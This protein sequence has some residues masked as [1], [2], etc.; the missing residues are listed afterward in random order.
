MFSADFSK[1]GML[2]LAS[3]G[4]KAKIRLNNRQKGIIICD[5]FKFIVGRQEFLIFV[6]RNYKILYD[7]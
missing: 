7:F 6:P 2:A 3:I 1:A 4:R 5:F